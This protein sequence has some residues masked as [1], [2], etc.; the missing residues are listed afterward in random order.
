MDVDYYIQQMRLKI[1]QAKY[2][3]GT[4][5]FISYKKSPAGKTVQQ[6]VSAN[7]LKMWAQPNTLYNAPVRRKDESDSAFDDRTAVFYKAKAEM[8]GRLAHANQVFLDSVRTAEL[9]DYIEELQ[10]YRKKTYSEESELKAVGLRTGYLQTMFNN[11]LNAFKKKIGKDLSKKERMDSF[12]EEA[13]R[14]KKEAQLRTGSKWEP[15]RRKEPPP[16]PPR[17]EER[18]SADEEESDHEESKE[19]SGPGFSEA[20]QFD[21][22]DTYIE[23]TPELLRER[24]EMEEEQERQE[25]EAW[26]KGQSL[27]TQEWD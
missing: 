24:R 10:L 3:Y 23:M 17:E 27:P 8:P 16:Q 2:P 6:E 4:I 19:G 21:E 15:P 18:S 14:L 25:T 7:R 13:I 26:E 5:G 11:L 12:V 20:D 1:S 9:Q 22:P